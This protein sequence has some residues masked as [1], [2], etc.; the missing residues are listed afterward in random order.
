MPQD[1]AT[2]EAGTTPAAEA[3][4]QTQEGGGQ[5][6]DLAAKFANVTFKATYNMSESG[7][8]TPGQTAMTLYKKG[9]NLRIDMTGEIEGQQQTAIYISRPDQSY[10]CSDIPE[11]GG[12]T[13]FSEPADSSQG[14]GDLISSLESALN[15]PSAEIV[16]TT[17]RTIAGEDATCYVIHSPDVDGESEVCLSNDAVPLYTRSTSGGQ[18]MS[19]EATSFGHDV[20]DSDFEPPYPITD[21]SGTP[22]GQ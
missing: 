21:I 5:F 14:A 12:S 7:G 8:D 11:M 19:L 20:S 3:T 2:S 1:G 22:T 15:D 18:E 13:C 9:D 16:S 4:P 17:S 10:L 6:S